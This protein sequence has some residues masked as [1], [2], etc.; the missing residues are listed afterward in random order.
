M[1][2]KERDHDAE[3]TGVSMS[4]VQSYPFALSSSRLDAFHSEPRYR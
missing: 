2:N 3:Q 1:V 4:A